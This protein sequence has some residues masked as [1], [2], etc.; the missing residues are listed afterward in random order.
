MWR[1]PD[2]EPEI[3]LDRDTRTMHYASAKGA[4]RARM[5]PMTPGG[6]RDSAWGGALRR[7]S[8]VGLAPSREDESRLHSIPGHYTPIGFAR[9]ASPTIDLYE[10]EYHRVAGWRVAVPRAIPDAR[11]RDLLRRIFYYGPQAAGYVRLGDTLVP[12]MLD[13]G[14]RMTL[15]EA[16]IGRDSYPLSS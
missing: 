16:A 15:S 4:G 8:D 5:E 3:G 12:A 13:P 9:Y 14:D 6:H 7:V 10:Y 1:D 2:E 11:A